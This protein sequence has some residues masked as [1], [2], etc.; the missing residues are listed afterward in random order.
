MATDKDY[1]RSLHKNQWAK[2]P[3][4]VEDA[5]TVL[6]PRWTSTDREVKDKATGKIFI[7]TDR[8]DV[9]YALV[10]GERHVLEKGGTSL[11]DYAGAMQPSWIW[12]D[13]RIPEG[14]DVPAGLKIVQRGADVHHYQIEITAKTMEVTAFQGALDTLV[15]NAFA[16]MKQLA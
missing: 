12:K 13:F 8:A 4:K 7:K 10:N 11:H 1:F 15:R 9:Q 2:V 3:L 14:T 6:D 5:D 16:R